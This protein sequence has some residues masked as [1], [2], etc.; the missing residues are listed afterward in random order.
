MKKTGA[1]IIKIAVTAVIAFISFYAFIPALNLQNPSFWI[2]TAWLGAVFAIVNIVVGAAVN[3]SSVKFG[4]K[5]NLSGISAEGKAAALIITLSV[6][7]LIVGNIISSTFFNA[8]AYASIIQV[9]EA[10]FEEDMQETEKVENIALMD[11]ASARK[12]ADRTLGGLSQMVSQ[13]QLSFNYSQINYKGAPEKVVNLEYADFFKWMNNRETGI[14]GYVMIDPVNSVSEYIKLD[15]AMRYVDSAYFGEDLQR[16]LRFSYPTKI[17]GSYAFE[18]DEAGNPFFIVSCMKPRIA[19]FGGM[20]VSEVIIFNPCDGTSEILSVKDVPSWVDNVYTGTLMS[21]K[22][23]W[24]GMLANGFFNSIVGQKDCKVTTDDFGYI[25]RDDDVW[26]YTGVTS[27]TN[28]E[29]NIG[30]IISNARTG[31]Y[32]YYSVMGAEE[33]SAMSAAEGAVQEKGYVAAFPALINVRSQATYIMVLKDNAGLVKMYAFVNVENYSIVATGTTQKA[34]RDEYVRLLIENGIIEDK[35]V[36]SGDEKLTIVI[37]DIRTPGNG[38]IY[39]YDADGNIF[40]KA[41]TDDEMFLK[42]GDKIEI[43]LSADDTAKVRTILSWTA[44]E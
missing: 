40:K 14:P 28:D 9:E 10:V 17:F 22:Y 25:I 35:N 15:K 23:D 12:L 16:K 2:F 30:F 24:H 20:D 5:F 44:V 29:S 7:V 41:V 32:K 18:I 37:S 4:R 39:L 38:Y 27:V 43:V 6:A 21:V 26:F 3:R 34:A 33:Y 13:Y 8:K 31:E 19:L 36:P 1:L 42:A 11:T